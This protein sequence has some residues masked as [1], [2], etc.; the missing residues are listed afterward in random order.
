MNYYNPII[1][2]LTFIVRNTNFIISGDIWIYTMFDFDHTPGNVEILGIVIVP[3]VCSAAIYL[4]LFM[5]KI[6]YSN[7]P[8]K[9]LSLM[10]RINYLLN[11]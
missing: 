4:R 9:T 3:L 2:K 5:M 10:L 7:H 6:E 1:D 11:Y 8:K